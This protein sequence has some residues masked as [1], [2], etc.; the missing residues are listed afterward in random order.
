MSKKNKIDMRDAFFDS[1][2]EMACH[3]HEIMFLTVD[4]GAFGLEKF[5]KD[6]PD[7]YIN[8]GIAEQNLIGVAS[9]LAL[10]GKIV[11]CYGITPFVSLRVL[12]QISLDMASMNLNVN[13]VSVGAGF[14]Y[15]TDGPSHHGLQDL[16]AILTIPNLK[17]FNSSDPLSTEAFARVAT[18]E[19]GAKYIRIEKGILPKLNRINHSDFSIGASNIIEGNDITIISTGSILHEARAASQLVH[20]ELGIKV[21]LIDIYRLKPFPEKVFLELVNDSK[22]IVTIEEGYLNGGLGSLVAS[23]VAEQ[24]CSVPVLKIGVEDKFCFDYGSRE[25]LRNL[26]GLSANKISKS[27]IS[28]IS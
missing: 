14:T 9:G 28:W 2:Y 25:Y 3:G 22:K 21:G 19:T 23:I 16:P 6:F 7:R 10:S 18:H 24:K 13:I 26:Y 5:Q 1:V 8:M 20:D 11:Y 27:I 4:H 12:E 15:S 17:V